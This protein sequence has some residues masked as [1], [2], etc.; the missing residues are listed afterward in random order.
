MRMRSV[1]QHC[2]Y[3]FQKNQVHPHRYVL[4]FTGVYGKSKGTSVFTALVL[5]NA[6]HNKRETRLDVEDVFDE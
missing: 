5:Q 3:Y 6:L 2:S 4:L 1:Q